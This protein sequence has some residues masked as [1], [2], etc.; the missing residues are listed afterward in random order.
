MARWPADNQT[1][2]LRFYGTPGPDVERQLV[3]VVPPFQMFYDGKPIKSIRFHKKAAPALAAALKEIWEHYGRD[4]KKIDAL[5]ISKYAGAYNPRKVRGSDTKWS[6]HAFGAA[7]DL[8]AEENGFGKGHGS[9]PQPVINAFKRQGARWGGDYRGRTD[10]MHFEFCDATGYPGPVA[11]M[12][13]PETDADSD[14]TDISARRKTPDTAVVT[15]DADHDTHVEETEASA[16]ADA[17]TRPSWLRRKWKGAT[18]WLFGGVG[19][20]GLGWLTDPW[21]VV[22]IGGVLLL[23]ITL[24]ILWMGPGDVRAWI[25]KQ[26][27]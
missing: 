20:V 2:L 7:I 22:A 5:G 16:E 24:F 4:Q 23:S 10:P 27:S 12:D 11:L 15:V 14:S 21:V 25:R 3:P 6:N 18:G 19:S 17:E 9:I 8:N 1:A 13:A 26:V